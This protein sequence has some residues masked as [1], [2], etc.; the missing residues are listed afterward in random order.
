LRP[1]N[2]DE[3]RER[4]R[5]C[6][7]KAKAKHHLDI[8]SRV[9]LITAAHIWETLAERHDNLGPLVRWPDKAANDK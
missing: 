3:M 4:A 7:A 1:M 6:R 9:L 2:S 8:H 5:Q